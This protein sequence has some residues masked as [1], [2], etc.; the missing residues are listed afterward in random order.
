MDRCG[1]SNVNLN[2]GNSRIITSPSFPDKYLNNERCLWQ[3]YAPDE[4][5]L[6]FRFLSFTTEAEDYVV[7]SGIGSDDK[8]VPFSGNV[9]DMEFKVQSNSVSV[10]FSSNSRVTDIGFQLKITAESRLLTDVSRYG[11]YLSR[12]MKWTKAVD[13]CEA[14]GGQ[15]AKVMD[16]IIDTRLRQ[17]ISS[18]AVQDSDFW[19][20]GRIT[21][22][23]ET[24]YEYQTSNGERLTWFKWG[25]GEPSRPNTD[26][27]CIRMEKPTADQGIMWLDH[28]CSQRHN[29]ICEFEGI[30]NIAYQ[31]P[32][33]FGTTSTDLKTA[34]DEVVDGRMECVVKDPSGISRRSSGND[35]RDA[36]TWWEVDLQ[37]HFQIFGVKLYFSTVLDGG[38]VV[39]LSGLEVRVGLQSMQCANITDTESQ[40][41]ILMKCEAASYGRY[42][43]LN[44]PSDRVENLQLCEFQVFTTLDTEITCANERADI[45][46]P[47]GMDVDMLY[48]NYGRTSSSICPSGVKEDYNYNCYLIQ[49]DM[50]K[51]REDCYNNGCVFEPLSENSQASTECPSVSP[52]FETAFQCCKRYYIWNNV[53]KTPADFIQWRT[54][55]DGHYSLYF[56]LHVDDSIVG[57]RLELSDETLL[58]QYTVTVTKEVEN[59]Q[60][61]LYRGYN[62]MTPT[63]LGNIEIKTGFTSLWLQRTDTLFAV[64]ESDRSPFIIWDDVD[65]VQVSR[66]NVKLYGGTGYI[67]QCPR[68]VQEIPCPYNYCH[69]E[70]T[71]Y[72][73]ASII[74]CACRDGCY[75]ALCQYCDQWRQDLLC[76]PDDLAPDGNP[77]I[78]NPNGDS[79]C[80]SADLV[81]GSGPDQCDCDT[82]IDYSPPDIPEVKT[83]L[84]LV[85]TGIPHLNLLCEPVRESV[86]DK[87]IPKVDNPLTSALKRTKCTD[88]NMMID[89]GEYTCSNNSWVSGE[90]WCLASCEESSLTPNSV[91]RIIPHKGRVDF[92]CTEG[93]KLIGAEFTLCINGAWTQPVPKC[94]PVCQQPAIPINGSIMNPPQG[95]IM[96]GTVIKYECI[97]GF[98]I[99]GSAELTC[100]DGEWSDS[101]PQCADFDECL[102]VLDNCSPNIRHEKCVNVVAGYTC[103]CADGYVNTTGKCEPLPIEQ[104]E[105][106]KDTTDAA[107]LRCDAESRDVDVW[108]KTNANCSTNWVPCAPGTVGYM[109]R[110]CDIFGN[111]LPPDT[112]DCISDNLMNVLQQ[113]GRVNDTSAANGLLNDLSNIGAVSVS[114]DLLA[115][116]EVLREVLKINPLEL[117]GDFDAKKNIVNNM[118]AATANFLDDNQVSMWTNVYLYN[119]PVDGAE[120]HVLNMQRFSDN[121]VDFLQNTSSPGIQVETN[122]IKFEVMTVDKNGI[123]YPVLE[124]RPRVARSIGDVDSNYSYVSLPAIETRGRNDSNLMVSLAEY[125][126]LAEILPPTFIGNNKPRTG[127]LTTSIKSTKSMK[128][129]NSVV[130]A[131][132]I[133]PKDLRSQITLKEPISIKFDHRQHG[134][135]PE[136]GFVVYGRNDGIWSKDGCWEYEPDD[137]K[138]YTI[139]QCNHMT[140]FGVIMEVAPHFQTLVQQAGEMVVFIGLGVAVFLHFLTFMMLVLSGLRSDHYF[141]LKN[142]STSLFAWVVLMFVA[143]LLKEK[144]DVCRYIAAAVHTLLLTSCSW[145]MV[146]SIQLFLRLKLFI[147]RSMKA[148]IAYVFAGWVVPAVFGVVCALFSHEDYV[149]A[150]GC[151]VVTGR[152]SLTTI[153]PALVLLFVTVIILV[154]TYRILSGYKRHKELQEF[155]ITWSDIRAVFVLCP[156]FTLSWISAIWSISDGIGFTSYIFSLMIFVEASSVFLLCFAANEEV[157]VAIRV[158]LCHGFEWFEIQKEL[159]RLDDQRRDMLKFAQEEMQ[160]KHEDVPVESTEGTTERI[161]KVN[162]YVWKVNDVE[163]VKEKL[164]QMHTPCI[165]HGQTHGSNHVQ[166]QR[167]NNVQT[168]GSNHVPTKDRNHS[169]VSER[170]DHHSTQDRRDH[171]QTQ[172]RRDHYQTIEKKQH[173]HSV[174]RKDQYHSNDRKDQRHSLDRK[175]QYH[176]VDRKDQYRSNDRKDQY[177]SVDRKDQY[178]SKDRKDQHQSLDRRD[179]YLTQDQRGHYQPV[180]RKDRYPTHERRDHYESGGRGDHM[181]T[182]TGPGKKMLTKK[183][184]DDVDEDILESRV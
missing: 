69:N 9:T 177:H 17:L 44:I 160:G 130:F 81:C 156:L 5:Q 109:K 2:V 134:S 171:Y 1:E 41:T 65:T 180:E 12:S 157:I 153:V 24:G 31:K 78:C 100:V 57:F 149:N 13:M 175:E 93:Y 22:N 165:I 104:S 139:C 29:V 99:N 112:S 48:A 47:D 46:C 59:S 140:E 10:M 174:D 30:V 107:V 64:S 35:D 39:D 122:N 89:G 161:V 51:L 25:R 111:W 6:Y 154:L 62:E 84:V 117:P 137:E 58:R 110:S 97:N 92:R 103:T 49:D 67:R 74:T 126:N 178:R 114:G 18:H 162:G 56:D 90:A 125:S 102:A 7:I 167:S 91:R 87:L 86:T 85:T 136:C 118:V 101:Y 135:N 66:V 132:S 88:G 138:D 131:V 95:D 123:T 21:D 155:K 124:N 98:Q 158:K 129:V 106:C 80:C 23:G 115:A 163:E 113:V 128:K 76:G 142:T 166:T 55:N 54:S 119:G 116:S 37:N 63:K 28:S 75:G 36:V 32:T 19:I 184:S 15:L 151:W 27:R 108:P 38:N 176:S 159:E 133:L 83:T 45:R 79:P 146:E 53:T 143:A 4:A 145:L 72:M 148:R 14:K 182:Y 127:Q 172:D 40:L 60:I 43:Q 68:D 168:H 82:C 181:Y 150:E 8:F 71:C 20:N 183:E 179:R 169:H 61:S 152:L 52:Y 70:A 16:S 147:Y 121:V 173:Y 96:N 50:I 42:I 73:T 11:L 170:R 141:I 33:I 26:D 164:N 94:E 77:A 144:T 34:A 105:Y 120:A 3:I